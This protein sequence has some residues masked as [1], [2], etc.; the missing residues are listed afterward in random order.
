M[1]NDKD[2]VYDNSTSNDMSDEE[3]RLLELIGGAEPQNESEIAM[4]KEF[5]EMRKKGIIIEIPP[6]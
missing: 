2:I 5:E 1:G 4:V 3:K 6:M